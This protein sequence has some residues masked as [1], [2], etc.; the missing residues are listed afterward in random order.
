MR[1]SLISISVLLVL[2]FAFVG[3]EKECVPKVTPATIKAKMRPYTVLGKTYHPKKVPK[4]QVSYGVSSWYGKK[5]NNKHTSSGECYNMYQNT[6]AHT[7]LPMNTMVRVCN[8]ENGKTTVVRINDRGPFSR[9]RVLDCSYQAGKE[10]GLDRTGIANVSL[11]VLG[12]AGN[13]DSKSY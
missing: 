13:L 1:R 8:L 7:T 6:A 3:C 4:G 12:V 9:G 2:G 11:E 10:I 5:F